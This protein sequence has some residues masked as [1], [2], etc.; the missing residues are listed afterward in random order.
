LPDETEQVLRPGRLA[1]RLC[2]A[3]LLATAYWYLGTP[4]PT[5][6]G[7][8]PRSPETAEQ[9]IAWAVGLLFVAPIL[10]MAAT[11]ASV[12]EAGLRLGDVSYG[13]RAWLLV[14][15]IM[16]PLTF[17]GAGDP[18]VQ[19]TYPWAGA[20]VGASPAAL[21]RWIAVLGAYYLAF[22]LFFRGF[23]VQ[24]IRPHWGVGAAIWVQALASTLVHAG[25]PPAETLAA[26]PAGLLLGLM[27][28]RSRSIVWPALLHLAVGISTDLFVLHRQGFLL[29]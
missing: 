8:A 22:E 29:P 20:A 7:A 3:T 18:A 4:G 21:G 28:V 2:A 16:I 5:L 25:K 26:L 27:A 17:L 13:V 23:L 15:A 14:W 11:G 1:V 10:V 9:G 24:A 6:L 19:A 12:R